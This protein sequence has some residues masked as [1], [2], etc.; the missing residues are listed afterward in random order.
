[1]EGESA[2][3]GYVAV[4]LMQSGH[5]I[6]RFMNIYIAILIRF[7]IPVQIHHVTFDELML[8]TSLRNDSSF[9]FA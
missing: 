5:D 7:S 6:L 1:M 3:G 8:P 2:C 9:T 4:S